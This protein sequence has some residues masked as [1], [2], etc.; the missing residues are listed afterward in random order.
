V[1]ASS[2]PPGILR[3]LSAENFRLF[4]EIKM[5]ALVLKL[6]WSAGMSII[7][8][9]DCLILIVPNVLRC[10]MFTNLHIHA[11]NINMIM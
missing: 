8:Y 1:V 3:L 2:L 6:I 9:K 11:T 4:R 5:L 7:P 10:T